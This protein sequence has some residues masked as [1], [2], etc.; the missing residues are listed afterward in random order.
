MQKKVLGILAGVATAHAVLLVGLMAGGGCRQPEI[1]GPHTYNNGPEFNPPVE[2]PAEKPI[3]DPA[4][5]VTPPVV[6]QT[7]VKPVKPVA[8]VKQDKVVKPVKPAPQDKVVKPVP[9]NGVI[10][11]K[12]KKGD[13]LSVIAY[14]HGLK[15][16]ELAAYNNIPA[17][18]RNSIREGQILNIPGAGAY[19][20]SK[21]PAKVAP[22]AQDSKKVAVAANGEYVVKP[23]DA[24]ERIAR[25]HGVSTNALAQANNM[26]KGD[27]LRPGQKLKI[28]ARESSIKVDSKKAQ[29][30]VK[31]QSDKKSGG[32]S[33]DLD[34]LDV[35]LDKPSAG[36]KDSSLLEVVPVTSDMSIEAFAEVVVV[37]VSDIRKYN[38]T[39]PAD[40]KL[41]KGMQI[42]V[43]KL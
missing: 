2:K 22:P 16:A 20:D 37:D 26:K 41:K 17:D 34:D 7:P 4:K 40:G 15:T 27:I 9:R 1:L 14:R 5:P 31:P 25:R 24:L 10:Q 32:Q 3:V 21:A 6:K 23:G 38:P 12:V 36:D 11:Y 28:P 43:P 19:K 18:K 8:P 29:T 39:L 42:K 33:I 35:E 30:T 13:S